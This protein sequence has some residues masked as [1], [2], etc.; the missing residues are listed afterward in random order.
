MSY[1]MYLIEKNIIEI[2]VISEENI[3]ALLKNWSNKIAK[4]LRIKF[5]GSTDIRGFESQLECDETLYFT[6]TSDTKSTFIV[7]Y[8]KSMTYEDLYSAVE[9]K[10][11]AK[12]DEFAVTDTVEV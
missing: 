1:M 12:R 2:G 6:D 7:K 8:L 9:E 11:E 4:S 3:C 5:N 10:L